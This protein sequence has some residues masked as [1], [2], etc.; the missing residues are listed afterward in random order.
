MQALTEKVTSLIQVSQDS[1]SVLDPAAAPRVWMGLTILHQRTP[2]V[3]VL[4][5]LDQGCHGL[6]LDP[7]ASE[8]ALTSQDYTIS[9][10]RSAALRIAEPLQ[11][12]VGDGS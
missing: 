4:Q 1:I 6:Y 10:K 11:S 7:L 8:H 9:G 5:S 2:H 12:K 3:K